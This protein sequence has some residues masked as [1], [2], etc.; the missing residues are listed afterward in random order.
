MLRALSVLPLPVLAALGTSIG[1]ILFLSFRSRRRIALTNLALCFPEKD[2][3]ERQRLARRSFCLVGQTL[4]SA[5]INWWASPGRLNRLVQFAGREYLQQALANKQNIILLAP[6]FIALELGGLMISQWQP[7]TAMYQRA[8]N[9]L[10]D[11]FVRRGRSRFGGRLIERKSPLRELIKSIRQGLPFYYLPDQDAGRKGVFVPFFGIPTATIPTLGRFAQ[12]G[13]AVVLPCT[14]RI[15]PRGQGWE[16]IIGSP[17]ALGSAKN[18]IEQTT[19]MNQCIEQ[20]IRGMPEQY[21]WVH[22][23][24]KT[25]PAGEPSFYP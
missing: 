11:E 23:R 21:F 2:A 19:V 17:L 20:A 4:V 12:L 16:V 7:T 24:F 6:H 13:K 9:K 14:T 3:T 18:E 1:N 5:G 15:L 8:N 22:K 10:A 25:R